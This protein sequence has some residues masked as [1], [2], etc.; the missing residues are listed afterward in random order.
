MH[1]VF[2]PSLSWVG[3]TESFTLCLFAL[4]SLTYS[5]L[6]FTQMIES[7][8]ELSKDFKKTEMVSVL[9]ALF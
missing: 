1:E 7:T 4:F 2:Y 9:C 5:E 3:F 8:L 6:F